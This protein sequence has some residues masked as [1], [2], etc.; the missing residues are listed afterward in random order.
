[1]DNPG[2]NWRRVY[3]LRDF[4][5]VLFRQA[6]TAMVCFFLIVTVA[7]AADPADARSVSVGDAD[8]RQTRSRRHADHELAGLRSRAAAG[9]HR[10]GAEFGN[11]AAPGSRPPRAGGAGDQARRIAATRAVGIRCRDG[12]ASAIRRVRSTRQRPDRV[13]GDAGASGAGA[14]RQPAGRRRFGGRG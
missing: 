4:S 2:T 5:G 13:R 14:A 1:M 8:P 6:P 12:S 10:A 9:R 11:R 3:T 7:V